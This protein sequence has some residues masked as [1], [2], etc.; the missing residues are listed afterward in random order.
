[1]TG[2]LKSIFSS[3]SFSYFIIFFIL[4][5]KTTNGAHSLNY[6]YN[7]ISD[8]DN[9]EL[10]FKKLSE[11]ATTP[12]RASRNAAGKVTKSSA[13]IAVIYF[14]C[15]NCIHIAFFRETI[16]VKLFLSFSIC[17]VKHLYYLYNSSVTD[18]P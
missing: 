17:N 10:K 18:S 12:L 15:F 8:D 6:E 4:V 9:T 2:S 13:G 5:K 11:N 3:V 1:M 7:N 16:A 14:K